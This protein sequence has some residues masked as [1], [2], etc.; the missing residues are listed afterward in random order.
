MSTS[1]FAAGG[2]A[3]SRAAQPP[4]HLLSAQGPVNKASQ[5]GA[6]SLKDAAVSKVRQSP[7]CLFLLFSVDEDRAE[8]VPREDPRR[9]VSWGPHRR[10]TICFLPGVGDCGLPGWQLF[11][12]GPPIC[13]LM[14]GGLQRL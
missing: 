3:L 8:G 1:T 14:A 6:A 13:L 12:S 2:S 4:T 9:T 11:C 10:K 5:P 7:C